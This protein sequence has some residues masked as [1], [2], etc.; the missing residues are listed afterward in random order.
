M[1]ASSS[2]G[3]D[4]TTI[5]SNNESVISRS[6][7]SNG[8]VYPQD[9]IFRQ[10]LQTL[11]R[12]ERVLPTL[13]RTLELIRRKERSEFVLADSMRGLWVARCVRALLNLPGG[14]AALLTFSQERGALRRLLVAALMCRVPM[15][16]VLVLEMLSAFALLPNPEGQNVV[17]NVLAQLDRSAQW[18]KPLCSNYILRASP[19]A[20]RWSPSCPRNPPPFSAIA[21]LLA[22]TTEHTCCP[23]L[24]CNVITLF[25][26]LCSSQNDRSAAQWTQAKIFLACRAAL[27]APGQLQSNALQQK[28]NTEDNF[29]DLAA[30]AAGPRYTNHRT[31]SISSNPDNAKQRARERRATLGRERGSTLT[32]SSDLDALEI[33]SMSNVSDIDRYGSGINESP[34]Q[35]LHPCPPLLTLCERY[36]QTSLDN[37]Y[38]RLFGMQLEHFLD[39]WDHRELDEADEIDD[40][41]VGSAERIA[42]LAERIRRNAL[43][44]GRYVHLDDAL[45]AL[46]LDLE[47]AAFLPFRLLL[48]T[49]NKSETQEDDDADDT[50]KPRLLLD[51]GA[52]TNAIT[53][54]RTNTAAS[55]A[56][57]S[58][59]AAVP[60]SGIIATDKND[61]DAIVTAAASNKI[62]INPSSTSQ[63]AD[64]IALKDDP[65]YAK[66]FR[67]VRMHV[68]RMAVAAKMA[69]EGLDPAVLDMD[70][71]GPAP[72]ERAEDET[73]VAEKTNSA[74]GIKEEKDDVQ[75]IEKKEELPLPLGCPRAPSRKLRRVFWEV[76]ADSK[77]TWW[78]DV[79]GNTNED[80]GGP[81]FLSLEALDDLE[82][83]FGPTRRE[84]LSRADDSAKA[85][86]ARRAKL[87]GGLA[88]ATIAAG[89][90]TKE[91]VAASQR[92]RNLVAEAL[93]EK[94]AFTLQLL[95][96]SLRVNN[97][98]CVSAIAE[99][100]P[101]DT[102]FIK[103]LSRLS[104]IYN[105]VTR[106]DELSTI[107][108]KAIEAEF[109]Q[110]KSGTI[111]RIKNS[112]NNDKEKELDDLSDLMVSLIERARR[113][114]AK[115]RAL[116][117]YATVS[118][119]VSE[120]MGR[121]SAH[122]KLVDAILA[123]KS[124]KNILKVVLAVTT[125]L[126]HGTTH[127]K[128]RGIRISALTKLRNTKTTPPGDRD[129]GS[130]GSGDVASGDNFCKNLLQF[131]I[132]HCGIT[133]TE[134][135]SEISPTM[136]KN[137]YNGPP[138]ETIANQLDDL[139]SERDD[140]VAERGVLSREATTQATG[141]DARRV[142]VAAAAAA[143]MAHIVADVDDELEGLKNAFNQMDL[144]VD[145]MLQH[146]GEPATML[147]ATDWFKDLDI[148]LA[149]YETEYNDLR[150]HEQR[151]ERREVL[152]KKQRARE[153]F[154]LH[155]NSDSGTIPNSG[156]R[157]GNNTTTGTK[158]LASTTPGDDDGIVEDDED[159]KP[160]KLFD[161]FVENAA[162]GALVS[163]NQ[164][165]WGPGSLNKSFST[166]NVLSTMNTST[167]SNLGSATNHAAHTS[168]LDCAE[169]NYANSS[170]TPGAFSKSSNDWYC[171][172]CWYEFAS[173]N[174]HWKADFGEETQVESAP[175]T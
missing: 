62:R 77:D 91:A 68:P 52:T 36:A 73:S 169:C 142:A 53:K 15:L 9:S 16:T 167:H 134:L 56:P 152:M 6:R 32:T 161:K 147:D 79:L 47:H 41:P 86:A 27:G 10:R 8:D 102:I 89:G 92:K 150:E 65:K 170:T 165:S 81:H 104:T 74:V 26:A 122:Q 155:D 115:V 39:G 136:L 94:R 132:R 119:Q 46:G 144:A 29:L 43:L 42:L 17:S 19:E 18:G 146:F 66:F 98:E 78:D 3:G 75:E 25:A 118:D 154:L 112:T 131:I 90:N 71:H 72:S 5:M 153:S 95:Y 129:G 23:D 120:L 157:G 117:L 14:L 69:A 51:L 160:V 63:E 45:N 139:R 35:A 163:E 158:I 113:P 30:P 174:P 125:F 128:V 141:A 143:R 137:V 110:K 140:A 38:D 37:H 148:F 50:G 11:L 59:S 64:F 127:G 33:T 1:S 85:N 172:D 24:R 83:V 166:G 61:V 55:S 111:S 164:T 175:D 54:L 133:A 149:H 34:A 28:K 76:I 12:R 124:L 13:T 84:A 2:T 123:S 121:I 100:D 31:N 60:S 44:L 22:H 151:K 116:W 159:A 88:L 67:M 58:S 135:K 130:G 7:R 20:L 70:P 87:A 171:A 101:K 109:L 114:R 126:N 156:S 82:A 162:R 103:N 4:K 57:S 173:K 138:R 168:I 21:T 48:S 97:E 99:L 106:S 93:G 145:S 107:E 105:M 40:L 108:T 49:T 96:S 80:E